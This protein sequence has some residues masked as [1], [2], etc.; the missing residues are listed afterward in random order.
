MSCST[1]IINLQLSDVFC[2]NSTPSAMWY[3]TCTTVTLAGR[4]FDA[5]RAGKGRGKMPPELVIVISYQE[6]EK[7]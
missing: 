3:T 2:V 5:R 7:N 4:E 6:G 1:V